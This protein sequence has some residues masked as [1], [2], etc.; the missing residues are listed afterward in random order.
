[1]TV[2]FIDV[3]NHQGNIDW[4]KV[5]SA[6]KRG[7]FIKASE[8]TF[9]K[10]PFFQR[11]WEQAAHKELWRG[12]YHFARP[13]R[14]PSGADEAKFFCDYVLAFPQLPGDMYVIDLEEGPPEA[15]L[16]AYMLNWCE[17]V[18]SRTGVKPLI[19]SATSM[20]RA[21]KLANRDDL[22][23]YGLWLAAPD[24]DEF[25]KPPAKWKVTAFWQH[26]WHGKVPGVLGDCDL[27]VF[28]GD[29]DAL[30]KYGVP[31]VS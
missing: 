19:Y 15:D 13:G 2:D 16:G 17:T 8:G 31:G 4:A 9:F 23:A 24:A 11:N 29:E 27:D 22:A 1:M 12:A 3:S 21:W 10:D 26:D 14:G 6:G 5:K 18:E 25:P 30:A 28:N 7:T 20:L